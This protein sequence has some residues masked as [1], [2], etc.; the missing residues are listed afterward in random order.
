[1]ISSSSKG[2]KLEHKSQ[3][4]SAHQLPVVGSY[5]SKRAAGTGPRCTAM[6]T[7]SSATVSST[8]ISP[9]GRKDV[10]SVIWQDEVAATISG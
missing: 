1:M 9:M 7:R 5:C 2:K 8:Q 6:G 3:T 10:I 4:A